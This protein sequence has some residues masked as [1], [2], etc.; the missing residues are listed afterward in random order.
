MSLTVILLA[1]PGCYL[2]HALEDEPAADA[3]LRDTP[4]FDA[5]SFDAPSFDARTLDAPL[6][7]GPG[8]DAG[9]RLCLPTGTVGVDLRVEIEQGCAIWNSL[10]GIA[11][12]ATITREESSLTIDFGSGVVFT[13]TVLDGA[14]N[15][16][17]VHGHD[18][19]DDCDWQATETL[20]GRVLDDDCAMS[21]SYDYEE[22]V[23][24]GDGCASPCSAM[25]NVT[26]D[27]R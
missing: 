4:R 7:G 26:L 13:G 21:L 25:A 5:P 24:S 8:M 19:F 17:Y 27:L 6:D 20:T 23:L 11:D 22:R 10:D 1:S 12:T 3:S 9:P 2:S 16:A 14:V 18:F 15:L